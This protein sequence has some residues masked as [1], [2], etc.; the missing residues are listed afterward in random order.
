MS[1]NLSCNPFAALFSSIKEAEAFT[2]SNLAQQEQHQH[3]FEESS[4]V[5]SEVDTTTELLESLL[6]VTTR[7][8]AKHKFPCVLL[9]ESGLSLDLDNV[10]F[11]LFERTLLQ[12]PE[13]HTVGGTDD[14]NCKRKVIPYLTSCYKRCHCAS[15]DH[16]PHVTVKVKETIV[17][18]LKTAIEQPE[19]YSEQEV[20][21]QLIQLILNNIGKNDSIEAMINH[22]VDIS[23]KD[24]SA[25]PQVFYDVIDHV[26]NKLKDCSLMGQSIDPSPQVSPSGGPRPFMGVDY[27]LIQV[28]HFYSLSARLAPILVALPKETNQGKKGRAYQNTALGQLLSISCLP[29]VSGKKFD[30]FHEP[31]SLTHQSLKTVEESIWFAQNNLNEKTYRIFYSI[32]KS[33]PEAKHKLLLWLEQCLM[34][35]GERSGIWNIQR[36]T[37][38][39]NCVCDGFMVNL[40]A[41]LL[42]LSQPFTQDISAGKILKIDPTFCSAKRG[43]DDELCKRGTYVGQL[44]KETCL[45]PCEE[46]QERPS[47]DNYSFITTCFFLTHRA[48]YLGTQVV[49]Q[50]LMKLSQDVGRIQH[51]FQEAQLQNSPALSFIRMQTES[52]MTQFLSYKAAAFQPSIIDMQVQFL[53]ATSEWLVQIALCNV[54]DFCTLTQLQ[55]LDVQRLSEDMTPHHYLQCIPEFMV[56]T[57][58]ETMRALKHYNAKLLHSGAIHCVPHLMSFI[59][60]FMGSPGLMKNPHH[61]AFLAECLETLLPDQNASGLLGDFVA[62]LFTSHPGAQHMVPALLNVFVSIE[63]TGMSVAFEEKFNYRRP[64]YEIMKY[65]WD[66]PEHS[67]RFRIMAEE[68]LANMEAARPPLFLRFINLLINDA[69]FLLDEGLMFM[70][71]LRD[72][73]EQRENEWPSLPADQRRERESS[74]QHTTLLARFHNLQGRE[75]IKVL[76]KL[77]KEI[78]HMFTHKTLVD[79]VAAMLNHFLAHLVGKKQKQLKVKD[80]EKYEFQPREMVSNIC[81]IYSHLYHEEAFCRAVCADG[82]SYNAQMFSQAQE[83]L[84]R[85]KRGSLAEQIEA[86]AQA[87]QASDKAHR[88]EEDLATEAP[89]E[90]LDPLMMN[91]MSDP[92]LLPSSQVICDRQTIARHLLS[93]QTDP[94]NRQPLTMEDVIPQ[95]ELSQ[96]IQAWMK[97]KKSK[98]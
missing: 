85:I 16:L 29:K 57:V 11:L 19:L 10:D 78:S 77:T 21:K 27:Q 40:G 7:P 87:V 93:D 65:L 28:L 68:A 54:D 58:R 60:V 66:I 13:L 50:K 45:V 34:T 51:E 94:F 8:H 1:D 42:Q 89:E 2:S 14:D 25:L 56:E 43:S 90:F 41:V 39:A 20:N 91:I 97:E 12:A 4:D 92:V 81:T 55:P 80:M 44:G 70:T 84:I 79:R 73:E 83:V 63:M 96:R 37:D 3:T 38:S 6:R 5:I 75:T 18:I 98:W 23:T 24:G 86:V 31:S 59:L 67:Q 33:S 35:N 49:L 47:K 15:K 76:V 26:A 69:I 82:R 52:R 17:S 46:G 71:Q 53:A 48:I 32:L 9:Q 95:K 61:R 88:Q 64:M 30:Y 22:F 36:E 62:S 72:L 74:M